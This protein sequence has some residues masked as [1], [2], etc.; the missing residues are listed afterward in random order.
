[1]TKERDKKKILLWLQFQ[2]I[3]GKP[4]GKDLCLYNKANLSAAK[5]T[6]VNSSYSFIGSLSLPPLLQVTPYV[7]PISSVTPGSIIANQT[8]MSTL[9]NWKPHIHFSP[10]LRGTKIDS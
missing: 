7:L 3:W 1:M 9:L 6:S 5:S 2:A 8:R 4:C 10:A